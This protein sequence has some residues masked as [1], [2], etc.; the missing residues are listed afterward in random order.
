MVMSVAMV[1]VVVLVIM[2]AMLMMLMMAMAVA[3][4]RDSGNRGFLQPELRR[5]HAGAQHPVGRHGP[6]LNRQAAKR[7]A[8]AVERQAEI[9]QGAEEHIA[10]GAG[11]T[12]E[13]S[14]LR[15]D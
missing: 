11:E 3:S 2:T 14:N 15:H 10:R 5:R 12:I 4:R 1:M 9:Q 7:R 6:V 13:V 8:Q